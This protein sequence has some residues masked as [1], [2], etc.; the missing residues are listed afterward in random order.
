MAD[1]VELLHDEVD[2]EESLAEKARAVVEEKRD[3][4]LTMLDKVDDV[5]EALEI[6]AALVEDDLTD[7][8][9]EAVRFGRDSYLRRARV[10]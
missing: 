9:S 2:G 4:L 7:L 5:E 1:L 10:E 6:L 8:T 3:K